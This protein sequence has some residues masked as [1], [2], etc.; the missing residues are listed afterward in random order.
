[1]PS[2]AHRPLLALLLRAA[3][4]GGVAAESTPW[5]P[6]R[7]RPARAS[8]L[9]GPIVGAQPAG[10][11][12]APGGQLP[13]TRLATKAPDFLDG[14]GRPSIAPAAPPVV[15]FSGY[16]Q[17]SIVIDTA[18]RALYYVLS[19]ST[20]YRY[21]I[22]VGREGFAWRGTERIS[23]VQSWPDWRPPAEMRKRDPN[24]PL[25]MSGGVRNPL[26]ARALYLGSTLY[27][28]HGTNDVR[29]IGYAASS[30]CFRMM[31]AHV[32]HL[33]GLAGVGTTVR[34][35]DRLPRTIAGSAKPAG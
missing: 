8:A 13:A 1:M 4:A 22:S 28:I 25:V 27:R 5:E 12:V 21:P 15:P 35:L 7:D 26:G 3:S 18:G 16:G 6:F 34:V 30:G 31:N 14:G 32:L 17:G 33:S 24:L 9:G 29:S 20:A 11:A 19:A 10:P 2:T 23:R